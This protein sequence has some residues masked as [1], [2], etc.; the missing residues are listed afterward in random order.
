M[1]HHAPLSIFL[2]SLCYLSP[3][4]DCIWLRFKLNKQNYESDTEFL[5]I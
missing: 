3:S 2:S 1:T 4:A 5:C